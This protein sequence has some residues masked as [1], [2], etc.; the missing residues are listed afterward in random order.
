[1]TD[2]EF[3]APQRSFVVTHFLVVCELD[4]SRDFCQYVFGATVVRRV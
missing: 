2:N 4:R 3:P 1:M